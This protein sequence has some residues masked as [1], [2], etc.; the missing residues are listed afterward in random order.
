MDRNEHPLEPH[1]LGVPS[2][3]SKKISEHMVR[4]AKPCIYLVSI[5]ALSPNRPKRAST[6]AS[7]PWNT[8]RCIEKDLWAYGTFGTNHAPILHQDRPKRFL[9]LW[10]V[11]RKPCIYL[12]LRL[13]LSPNELK[14]HSTW[15]TS[16]RRSIGCIQQWF[17]SVWYIRR[18][19]WTYL[20][21]RLALSP[22]GMKQASTCTS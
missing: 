5:L 15:Q 8:I 19:P 7:S 20:A 3:A 2:G 16:P 13:T 10:Y 9:S 1:H 22:N 11:W 12:A 4:F 17:P 14:R 21:S 18:K 6:W